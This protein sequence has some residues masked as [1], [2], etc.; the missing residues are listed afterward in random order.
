MHT[1]RWTDKYWF[2][3]DLAHLL[4]TGADGLQLI[5]SPTEFLPTDQPS[6]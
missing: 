3:A 6:K 4:G 5:K 2:N 1:L